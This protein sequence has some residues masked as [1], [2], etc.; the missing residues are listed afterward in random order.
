MQQEDRETRPDDDGTPRP[1]AGDARP[2]Q[3][4]VLRSLAN[5][6]RVRRA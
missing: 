3:V 4:P 6:R 2:A 5:P 1:E